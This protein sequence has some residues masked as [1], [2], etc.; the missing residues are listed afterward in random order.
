METSSSDKFI[1]QESHPRRVAVKFLD[2]FKL[3]DRFKLRMRMWLRDPSL[4]I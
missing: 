4:K 3:P 1:S 2:D